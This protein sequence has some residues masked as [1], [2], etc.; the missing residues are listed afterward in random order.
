MRV[1]VKL[2]PILCKSTGGLELV[3]VKGANPLECLRD[4]ELQFPSVRRWLYDQQGEFRSEVLF[5][6]NGVRT[7]ADELPQ[8]LDDGDEVFIML[9]IA[10]G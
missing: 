4:L 5:F 7:F 9:A 2:A 3:E 10:G 8:Q 6:V 1:N